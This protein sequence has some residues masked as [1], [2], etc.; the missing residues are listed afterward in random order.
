MSKSHWLKD[1]DQKGNFSN[2]RKD[3]FDQNKGYTGIRLQQG[4]PLL[5]RDWNELED[6]RRYAEVMLRKYYIGNGVPDENSFKIMAADPPGNDFKIAAGRCLVEGLEAVNAPLDADG[7]PVDFIL[8]SQQ[9]GAAP[10]NVPDADRTDTVYLDVWI[11]EVNGA[12]DESLSN[13]QDVDME[14]CIRHKLE[15][16][17]RVAKGKGSQAPE[18]EPFHFYYVIATI[19][20]VKHR[21]VISNDDISDSRRTRLSVHHFYKLLPHNIISNSFMNRLKGKVPSGFSVGYFY[22]GNSIINIEAVHPFTKGFE[23]PYVA[24][25]PV[26]AVDHVNDATRDNPYWYGWYYKGPRISRGGM[27]DGWGGR[28]D[29]NILKITGKRDTSDNSNPNTLAYVHFPKESRILTKGLLFR[30]WIKIIKGALH[31]GTDTYVTPEITREMTEAAPDGWYFVNTIIDSLHITDLNGAYNFILKCFGEGENHDGDFE[32]YVALPYLANIEIDDSPHWSPSILDI[33]SDYGTTIDLDIGNIGIGT[34]SPEGTLHVKAHSNQWPGGLTLTS[35]DNMGKWWIH[36][37]NTIDHALMFS[38]NRKT[39]VVFR[40]GNVGIGTQEPGATLHVVGDGSPQVFVLENH[41]EADI[42]FRD[43]YSSQDWQVGTNGQGFFIYDNDYRLVVKK[44]GKVGIGTTN[45]R[46]ALEVDGLVR[47]QNTQIYDNEINRY[48]NDNLYIGYRNTKDTILQAN[49]GNVGIGRTSSSERLSIDGN[50]DMIGTNR[51]IYMGGAGGTTFGIAYDSIYPHHG[52][53]YT[54]GSPDFVSVSPNGDSKNGVMNILGSGKVGIGTPNPGAKLEVVADSQTWWGWNEAIRLG[55]A[56]H[57]AITHP[58]SGLLF[59]FHGNR[60]FY[61]ADTSQSQ[62]LMRIEATSTGGN[63]WAKYFSQGALDY[64]EYFE[65]KDGK[66]INAGT[67]VSIDNG[68]IRPAKKDEIPIGIISESPGL[69]GGVHIEWPGKYLKDEFGKQIMEEYQEEVMVAKKEKVKR[70]RQKVEKKKVKEEVK[71]FEVVKVKGK[72]CQK[73]I[74][75]TVERE[76]EEPVFKEVDLYDAKGKEKIGRHQIPVMESYEEE[77]DVL[78]EN[79]RP[80]MVG[81]GKFETKTR[82]K[83]NPDYD[84][85]KE[86]IPREK[87][88]EWNCVGLLGQLPLRKGQPTAPTWIKIKDISKDVELWLVK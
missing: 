40:N 79:G 49:G 44:G 6:M 11:R 48:N 18:S 32:I 74:G 41:G 67:S 55:P 68:K 2:E 31:F 66:E 26:N 45:P 34:P 17:V 70:E 21:N 43:T 22:Q 42:R 9:E 20:R 37:E 84:E 39:L 7:N 19:K 53:F 16:R 71:R 8:Y 46:E 29:G 10:L 59:G 25:K 50:I 28:K 57:S 4:V 12:E 87:R 82:P 69:V 47:I 33:L 83:L 36:P 3:T 72:Y 86:Y 76:V 56:Y 5:D 24:D 62:Y 80:V 88:P 85:T 35:Q 60:I 14:T 63:V 65:S 61:F 1:E 51:R 38:D 73:E 30:A 15:W 78:D 81:S 13:S 58:G 27:A 23:G 77:I 54:E 75:E 52:I 64:A